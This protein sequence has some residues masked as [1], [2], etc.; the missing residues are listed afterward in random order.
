MTL[1]AV[2]SDVV[3]A[4]S[5]IIGLLIEFRVIQSGCVLKFIFII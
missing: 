1:D 4:L 5:D 2:D 3:P